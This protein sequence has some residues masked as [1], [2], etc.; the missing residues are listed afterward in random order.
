MLPID[1]SEP[2]MF[3]NLI[4]I[5]FKA[6][7]TIWICFQESSQQTLALFAYRS[8]KTQFTI[9]NIIV[10]LKFFLRIK[11]CSFEQQFVNKHSKQIPIKRMVMLSMLTI[12]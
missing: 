3:L 11:R 1:I 5:I 2:W 6:N 4:Q 8:W 7:S 10:Q 12:K 9:F